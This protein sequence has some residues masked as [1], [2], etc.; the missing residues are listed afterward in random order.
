[1]HIFSHMRNVY[2]NLCSRMKAEFALLSFPLS[3]SCVCECV[4]LRTVKG[5]KVLAII[6]PLFCVCPG[7]RRRRRWEG[8]REGLSL[9]LYPPISYLILSASFFARWIF[10][11]LELKGN[12][13]SRIGKF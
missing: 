4:S 8:R 12:R 13:N 9:S 11:F 10:L 6:M 3:L 2:P 5:E 1:M 7:R